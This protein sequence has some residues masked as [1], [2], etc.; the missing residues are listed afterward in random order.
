MRVHVRVTPGA[1][2]NEVGGR[3][4]EDEPPVLMVRV[5]APATDGRANRAVVEALARAF[6]VTRRAVVLTAGASSRRKRV[7][8]DGATLDLL[9]QLLGS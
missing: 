3:Y 4:G 5:T 6:G 8:V 1:A 9:A 7:E 2:R